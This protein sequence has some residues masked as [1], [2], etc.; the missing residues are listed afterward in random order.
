MEYIHSFEYKSNQRK[1]GWELRH[2]KQEEDEEGDLNFQKG[3]KRI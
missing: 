2:M 1:R 3:T